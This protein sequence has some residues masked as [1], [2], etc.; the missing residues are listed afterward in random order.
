MLILLKSFSL[1]EDLQRQVFYLNSVV[2]YYIIYTDSLL[3]LLGNGSEITFLIEEIIYQFYISLFKIYNLA[4][5]E[6]LGQETPRV[7]KSFIHLTP[8]KVELFIF[9]IIIPQILL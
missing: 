3:F 5:F 1:Q 4:Y 2:L 7:V 6:N 8:L 9:V